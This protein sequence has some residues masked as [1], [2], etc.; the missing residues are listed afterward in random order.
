V[1]IYD[2]LLNFEKLRKLVIREETEWNY[3]YYPIIF[4]DEKQLLKVEKALNEKHIF[5]RRYFYPSLNT[6]NYVDYAEAKISECISKR[7][8]CLPLYK[9]LSISEIEFISGIINKVNL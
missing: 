6:L 4:E 7:I 5:P 9:D 3:S 1:G 8:L 2:E